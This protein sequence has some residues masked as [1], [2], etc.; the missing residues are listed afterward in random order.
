VKATSGLFGSRPEPLP[1]DAISLI[2]KQFGVCGKLTALGSERDQIVRI[3]VSTGS[4]YVLKLSN[5]VESAAV[6]DFEASVLEHLERVAP[7]LPVPRLRRAI[8]GSRALRCRSSQGERSVRLFTFL[9]GM[10]LGE[11]NLCVA[12]RESI[13]ATLAD[14]DSALRSM[15]SLAAERE[16]LWDFA[17]AS[18][19]QHLTSYVG[20]ASLRNRVSAALR[21]LE[22]ADISGQRGLRSQWLHNDFNLSNVLVSH[23]NAHTVCGIIDFGDMVFGPLICDLAVACAYVMEASCPLTSISDVVRGYH[24]RIPLSEPELVLLPPLIAA[25]LAMTITVGGWRAT[26]EPNNSDYILRNYPAAVAKL[27]AL[28]EIPASE[29][30][31][32]VARHM[33][34][35]GDRA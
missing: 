33:T 25:R 29:V 18:G 20:D 8:D 30:A 17:Q 1:M 34:V 13:G 9:E 2:A 11:A 24:A 27:Q 26:L 15:P 3:E 35:I 31:A 23:A 4:G 21:G 7:G 22:I 10:P 6:A 32:F 14:L 12:L 19:L 5:P 16:M 28:Q